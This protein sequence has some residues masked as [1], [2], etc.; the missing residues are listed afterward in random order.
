MVSRRLPSI[1][2]LA[3]LAVLAVPLPLGA[4]EGDPAT[5]TTTTT[6]TAMAVP[7]DEAATTTTSSTVP[8]PAAESDAPT[9]E[10][11]PVDVT[12]PPP[13]P[14]PDGA[15]S[16][17]AVAEARARQASRVVFRNLRGARELAEQADHELAL[18]Q[19]QVADLKS[20]VERLHRRLGGLRR[21]HGRAAARLAEAKETLSD[22][23][24]WAYMRGPLHEM[25]SVLDAKD[26]NEMYRRMGMVRSVL[27]A[28]QDAL[29]E[30]RAARRALGADLV[31]TADDLEDTEA[32]L[33]GA[34]TH[35]WEATQ[36]AADATYELAIVSAGSSIVIHGFV[37]PVADP[38]NFVD[39]FLAPRMPGTQYEHLHQGTD[40]FAPAG[41]P[42]VACER[43]VITKMGTDVLGGTKLWLVGES[44]ARY[45][46]AHLSAFAEDIHDGDVVEPGTVVGFVGNTGNAVGTPS[47]LHFEIHPGGGP[48]INP[49]PLLKAVDETD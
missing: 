24:A 27:D 14:P 2:G 11:P 37:F 10:V 15:L 20:K 5:T 41:T 26:P 39:T 13:P 9:E 31:A 25:T 40:I 8:D 16:E 36:R 17:Q 30:Y 43:G 48:A 35:V 34:E 28:D 32:E 47:H 29:E 46:Y 7:A 19:L 33:I 3:A 23:A 21:D 12:V 1:G 18:A 45:Y 44:G 6:T 4:Q 49:F 42:L 38:H 22:R